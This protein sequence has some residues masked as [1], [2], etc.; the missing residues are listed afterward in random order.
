MTRILAAL[1]YAALVAL[2]AAILAGRV[3]ADDRTVEAIA[4]IC[5]AEAGWSAL[6]TGDCAAIGHLIVRR[7]ARLE[8]SELGLA[9]AYSARHFDRARRDP[10]RWIAGLRIDGEQPDGWPITL[11]WPGRFRARWLDHVAFARKVLAGEVADPC[12][13]QADHWGMR[14]RWSVDWR[15]ATRA[16][17]T[18]LACC[19]SER[20]AFWST[21]WTR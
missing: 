9:R 12:E 15:R 18:L 7:A 3:H 2:Y 10:R 17:W 13:G 1:G 4:R 14:A 5:V 11:D 19:G 16:G 20:N 6:D 21:R 8:R